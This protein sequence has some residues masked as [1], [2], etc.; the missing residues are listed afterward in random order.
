MY[1]HQ[2]EQI[3]DQQQTELQARS[4]RS[5]QHGPV[6]PARQGHQASQAR[7]HQSIRRQQRQHPI[8]KRA[9]YALVSLGLRLA[10]VA[11]QD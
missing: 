11:D 8:R 2:I 3:A 6:R 1:T 4:A 10:S 5:H 9:G 7:S